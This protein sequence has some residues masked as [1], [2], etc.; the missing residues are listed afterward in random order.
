[1][2]ERKDYIDVVKA[3]GIIL[4]TMG[5]VSFG[6]EFNQ[7]IAGFHMPLFFFV[8]GYLFNDKNSDTKKYLI[9]K[10]QTLLLPYITFGFVNLV[11]WCVLNNDIQCCNMIKHLFFINTEGMEISG[12]LWFLSALFISSIILFYINRFIKNK[13]IFVFVILFVMSFG[14]LETQ[15]LSFRL[16]FAIGPG[17]VGSGI[18]YF[19]LI[20]R[21]YV[22]NHRRYK[23]ITYIVLF[24]F[25][26]LSIMNN[27]HV[28]M[29]TDSYAIIPVS[30][31]N[32]LIMSISILELARNL[33]EKLN[34]SIVGKKIINNF[35]L[36]GRYSLVYL[37]FNQTVIFALA[38]IVMQV[39]P[40]VLKKLILLV[41]T[42]VMLS[43]ITYAIYHTKIKYLLGV[44]R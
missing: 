13:I 22:D 9:N 41:M 35:S 26:S 20:Y 7:W 2:V 38:P 8:S 44:K 33:C 36:I 24:V 30:I 3:I 1:M 43:I 16:P 17:L 18:M 5:H 10:C 15:L 42:F 39:E 31:L 37:G 32:A 4:M 27:Q 6:S 11:I 23:S 14:L 12:P 40:I 25:A 34:K 19:G 28:N 29:R 21:K